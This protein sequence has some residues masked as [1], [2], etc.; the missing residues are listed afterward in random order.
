MPEDVCAILD[1]VGL[2]PVL[3]EHLGEG[4]IMLAAHGLL[5]LDASLDPGAVADVIDQALSL[6]AAGLAAP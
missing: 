2:R 3:V 4:A 5:I 1:V 6:G